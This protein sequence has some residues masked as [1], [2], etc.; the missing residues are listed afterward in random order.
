MIRYY[1]TIAKI[2]CI[3]HWNVS[4]Q[5]IATLALSFVHTG[6]LPLYP[7]DENG[8]YLSWKQYKAFHKSF[9]S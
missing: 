5:T 2:R 1:F 7:Q 9:K 3:Y 6:K 4:M 8:N